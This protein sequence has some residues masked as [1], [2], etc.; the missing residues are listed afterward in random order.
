MHKYTETCSICSPKPCN[1]K[2]GPKGRSRP[3]TFMLRLPLSTHATLVEAAKQDGVSLNTYIV[4]VLAYH[5]G[6]REQ[7]GDTL[8]QAVYRAEAKSEFD[9]IAEARE[10]P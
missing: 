3:A 1:G 10:Q 7:T 6:L 9:Y 2:G 8:E 4:T 5:L